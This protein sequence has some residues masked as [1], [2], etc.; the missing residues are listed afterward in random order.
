MTRLIRHKISIATAAF[1]FAWALIAVFE[2]QSLAWQDTSAIAKPKAKAKTK[3]SG[4]TARP[5]YYQGRRIAD[6]MSYEGAEWLIRP[7]RVDEEQPDKMLDALRI[8]EGATVAD[9]GAGVGYTSLKIAQRV[10]PKGRVLATDLQP[11]MLRMLADNAEAAGVTNIKGIRCT[12]TDP[13]LPENA[14][15]LIIMVD[16][17]HECSD[18]EATLQGL[19]KALKP[20]GRL[21][22][23]EYRGEDP[24]VPIKPEHK[25]TLKQ[26]RK[27]LEPQGFVFKESLEFLPWQHLIILG[28]SNV[29]PMP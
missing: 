27:E 29:D 20:D 19:R 22:L 3:T 7:S 16:V 2:A 23:V 21:V 11:E 10:G 9:V 8:P 15:D 28:K 18:P 12:P 1:L 24:D 14:V 25:M 6:V 17:Y 5:G 4:R 26:V 13:K